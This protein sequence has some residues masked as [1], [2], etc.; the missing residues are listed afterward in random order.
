MRAY[1]LARA[2]KKRLEDVPLYGGGG[3]GQE[4]QD[5]TISLN[6]AFLNSLV[7]ISHIPVIL[8]VFMIP[9]GYGLPHNGSDI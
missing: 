6:S 5:L 9:V 1:G 7:L 3:R 4:G 8:R 2:H